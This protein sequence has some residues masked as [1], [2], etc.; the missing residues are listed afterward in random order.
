MYKGQIIDRC[1]VD[2]CAAKTLGVLATAQDKG[3]RMTAIDMAGWCKGQN[4]TGLQIGV[5]ISDFAFECQLGAVAA[6]DGHS[7]AVA[8]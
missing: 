2:G 5:E 3:Q 6:G 7:R 4:A 1:H 8:G